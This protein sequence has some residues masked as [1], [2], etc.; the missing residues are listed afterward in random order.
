[1]ATP[2][3]GAKVRAAD[4]ATVFPT[5]TDGWTNYTPVITQSNTPTLSVEYAQ[6]MKIGRLVLVQ[7]SVGFSTAGTASNLVLCTLPA[8]AGTPVHFRRLGGAAIFDASVSTWYEGMA[9]WNS[10]TTFKIQAHNTAAAAPLGAGGGFTAALASGDLVVADLV[11]A[12][13]S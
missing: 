13:S 10:S 8:A 6:Y 4:W 2:K 1:M 9:L 5:D 7:I 12:V 3:A 11:Y